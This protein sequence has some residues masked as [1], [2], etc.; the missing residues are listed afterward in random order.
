MSTKFEIP[1]LCTGRLVLR[2]FRAADIDAWAAM[3]ADPEVRRYRGNDPRSRDEA[4]T[5]MQASLGQWAL[6]GYGVFAVER[7]SDGGF[8][9]IAGIMHPADWPEPELGYSLARPAWGN[10]YAIEAAAAARDW[11][12]RSHGFARLASF[13]L[14][15]NTRSARVA[16]RL[17]AILDGTITLRGFQAQ[18]WV[19]RR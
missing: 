8:I 4:W 13:I 9:G 15:E 2:A 1:T 5:A 18:W 10:G 14:P 19:H 12:F 17:G 7:I 16:E 11:A 3:E 6:R